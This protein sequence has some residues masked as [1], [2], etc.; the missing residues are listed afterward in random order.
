MVT[1]EPAMTTNTISVTVNSRAVDFSVDPALP[2]LDLLRDRLGLTGAKRGCAAQSCGACTVLLDRRPVRACAI[3]ATD[4]DGRAVTTMEGLARYGPL[5]P[6]QEA[7]VR[8]AAIGCGFCLPGMILAA[9]A[10]L[11]DRPTPSRDAIAECL[12]HHACPCGLRAVMVE[13]VAA[14]ARLMTEEPDA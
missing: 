5:H 1:V 3:A 8:A 14:A 12:S 6:V 10:L 7:F 9:T 2:L 4:V 13:A 11:A